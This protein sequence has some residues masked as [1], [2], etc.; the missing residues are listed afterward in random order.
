M[1]LSQ[2]D[3]RALL[4]LGV[5]IVVWL[6]ANR[7][8]RAPAGAA[9]VVSAADS[10]SMAEKRLARVRQLAASVPGKEQVLKQAQ[11]ELSARE[12]GVIQAAT[13]AQAQ[14]QVLEALRRIAGA[15]SPALELGAV[16]M[17]R[18]VRA[19]S[20]DYGEVSVTVPFTCT[21][22]ALVNYLADV[23]NAPEA[24]ATSDLR[25]APAD[26]K[27]KTVNVRLTVSAVVPQRL[28]P[29]KRGFTSF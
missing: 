14:A 27:Q 24:L 16:D 2:R 19:L 9:P 7:L 11:A 22:D 1:K 15:Q 23:A 8:W 4:I 13:A 5:A 6:A 26:A 18:E 25:V 12:K 29:E 28:V 10:I 17:S 21:I 20:P 3:R